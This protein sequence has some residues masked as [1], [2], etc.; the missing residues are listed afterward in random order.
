MLYIVCSII[1]RYLLGVQA[2]SSYAHDG[3]TMSDDPARKFLA[4]S[5]LAEG[6]DIYAGSQQS[7]LAPTGK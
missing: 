6:S 2:A 4:S 7:P 5:P 3:S 1:V